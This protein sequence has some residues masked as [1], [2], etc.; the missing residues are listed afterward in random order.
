VTTSRKGSVLITG[1]GG[2]IGLELQAT[3]PPEWEVVPCRSTDLDITDV[4]MVDRVLKQAAPAVVINAAAFTRVDDAE[5]EPARAE[6]VNASGAGNVAGA[7]ARL[8]VRLI[9]LSTDFVFDGAQGRPYAPDD[10]PNPLGVYGRTK[11]LGERL[12]Q[13]RTAGSGL[14]IRTAWVYAAAGHNF[15]RTMLRLMR[16]QPS[17]GV[18][19]DQIGTPTWARALAQA[20]WRA[21][22]GEALQGILHW[23]D[24][25][26]ASWYDFALAIQ[27]ESLALGLLERAV[28]IRPLHSQEYPTPARRPSYSVLDKSSG[29]A[30]LGG[31]APHWRINLRCMLRG[32]ASA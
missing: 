5:R 22:D 1:A 14:I 3:A 23:T 31:P 19:G 13:E 24:A 10:R 2:Q 20:L 25:G 15:V 9:H 4:A 26:V 7:A 16:E 28:P 8:G 30:A 11:L 27:E 32:L 21:V 12:V 29:W 17:I 6:A 18:V